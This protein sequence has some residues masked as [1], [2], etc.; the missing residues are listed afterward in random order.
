MAMT[1]YTISLSEYAKTFVGRKYLPES[2]ANCSD[3]SA[4]FMMEILRSQYEIKPR[5]LSCYSLKSYM[6]ENLPCEVVLKDFQNEDIIFYSGGIISILVGNNQ[7]IELTPEGL[8]VVRPFKPVWEIQ[9]G[10]R[11]Y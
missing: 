10:L 8:V 1:K 9:T 3:K 11:L 6:F 4:M 5:H 7:K 2:N